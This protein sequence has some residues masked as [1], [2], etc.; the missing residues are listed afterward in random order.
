MPNPEGINRPGGLLYPCNC[1]C[2]R[3]YTLEGDLDF[4]LKGFGRWPL[5]CPCVYR[6]SRTFG[7][8]K[9]REV[10]YA[11]SKTNALFLNQQNIT[12]NKRNCI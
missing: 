3:R 5:G 1:Y 8:K 2:S 11:D 7:C 6:C 10:Y 12:L 9:P 4:G